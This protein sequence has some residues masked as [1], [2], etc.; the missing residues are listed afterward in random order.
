VDLG[1]SAKA[2]SY[3]LI[4]HESLGS[5]NEEAMQHARAGDS[6]RLWII[7]RQQIEGRGR[8]GRNWISPPGNLYASVLLIDAAPPE[9]LPQLGFVAGVALLRALRD[10]LGADSRL[11]LKWP[12]DIL[13]DGAKLSGILLESAQLPRGRSACVAGFGV[14]CRSHPP[15]LPYP[16]TDLAAIG[17]SL[18]A[19]EDVLPRLSDG[20]AEML[21]VWEGGKGFAAI[22]R[23]W[24]AGALGLGDRIQVTL[25]SGSISGIFETIDAGGRL[26]LRDGAERRTIEAGDVFLSSASDVVGALGGSRTQPLGAGPST[27]L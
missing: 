24:L 17:T 19:P 16:A 10:S 27:P 21:Q 8:R 2:A 12:N 14:N 7:A 22:R 11:G 5:T 18:D 9:Q 15:A 13:F 6:G 23:H 1:A 3:R 26:V 4:V 20:M 25:G